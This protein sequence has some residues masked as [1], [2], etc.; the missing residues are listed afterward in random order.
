MILSITVY[1]LVGVMLFYFGWHYNQRFALPTEH[2]TVKEFML[3]WEII[4]SFV[5]FSLITGL[6]YHT[7]WD[8]ECYIQDYVN[9]KTRALFIGLTLNQDLDWLKR[10]LQNSVSTILCFSDS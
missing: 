8:H 1:T 6:R 7:G 3:S 4:A 10:Y 2:H 9:I 5:L